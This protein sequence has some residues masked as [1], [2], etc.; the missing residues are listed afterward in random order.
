VSGHTRGYGVCARYYD[1]QAAKYDGWF[2]RHPAAFQSELRAVRCAVTGKGRG[3]EIGVGTGRFAASLGITT[4]VDPSRGMCAIARGRGIDV[5]CGIAEE[6][7]FGDELFDVAVMVTVLLFITDPAAAIRESHR[8]LRSG[9]EFVAAFIDRNSFL[10]RHYE[11]EKSGCD[12]AYHFARFLAVEEVGSMLVDAG[13]GGLNFFQTIY[14]RPE[15]IVEVQPVKDGYG[16]GALVII[17]AV[18]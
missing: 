14:A 13:F 3:I 7:P 12:D 1:S 10:A 18:K 2:D 15:E 11:R 4:G 16:E 8:V 17:R 5:A 6:L 9:G